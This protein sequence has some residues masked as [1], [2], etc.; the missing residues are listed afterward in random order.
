[1][2]FERGFS[3]YWGVGIL[4]CSEVFTSWFMETQGKTCELSKHCVWHEDSGA[5]ELSGHFQSCLCITG[6]HRKAEPWAVTQL[7]HLWTGVRLVF[8]CSL[9]LPNGLYDTP[10]AY[11]GMW[12]VILIRKRS[13]QGG[14]CERCCSIEKMHGHWNICWIQHLW[15]GGKPSPA[16]VLLG[17]SIAGKVSV[18]SL[19]ED[20]KRP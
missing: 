18:L 9:A 16:G 12:D 3:S 7:T 10:I 20:P 1:V 6:A 17:Y 13:K 19:L 14:N 8:D 2:F 15:D 4:S 5:L 11:D